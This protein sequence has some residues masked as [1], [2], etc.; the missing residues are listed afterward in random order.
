MNNTYMIVGVSL[1]VLIA[2]GIFLYRNKDTFQLLPPLVRKGDEKGCK[3]CKKQVE[4]AVCVE[5]GSDE[6]GCQQKSV[7]KG[8]CSLEEP[9]EMFT[10]QD[11][12]NKLA[13]DEMKAVYHG[14]MTECYTGCTSTVMKASEVCRLNCKEVCDIASKNIKDTTIFSEEDIDMFNKKCVNSCQ[15]TQCTNFVVM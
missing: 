13:W 14:Y 9:V 1:I 8:V 7:C 10:E 12:L 3:D 15:V 5:P 11:E 2:I 4:D 6:C